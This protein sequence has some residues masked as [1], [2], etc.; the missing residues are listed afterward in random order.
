MFRSTNPKEHYKMYKKGKIWI[1]AGIVTTSLVLGAAGGQTAHADTVGDSSAVSQKM[2]PDK[3]ATPDGQATLTA[4]QADVSDGN[5][6]QVTVDS[7]AANK[8][9]ENKSDAPAPV[10][11]PLADT[12]QESTGD[13]TDKGA[14]VTDDDAP[15]KTDTPVKTDSLNQNMAPTPTARMAAPV[16]AADTAID[17]WMPNKTLQADVLSTLKYADTSKNPA[18]QASGKTW[19]TV[20]DITQADMLLLNNFD[21]RNTY[22]DGKQSFSIKGLEFATNLTNLTISDDLNHSPYMVRGDVTDLTPLKYLTKL[23][24]LEVLGQRV[25]DITP[26][27]GLKNVKNL[28][29]GNNCIADFSSLNAAQYSD[30][31]LDS[32]L[33][34]NELIYMPKTDKYVLISPV[35]APQGLTFKLMDLQTVTGVPITAPFHPD[36]TVRAFW[37]GA[38]SSDTLDGDKISY[39]GIKDQIMPGQTNNPWAQYYPNLVQEDYA[40]FLNAVYTTTINGKDVNVLQMITPYVK[41]DQAANVTINYVDERGSKVAEPDTLT[42]FIGEDYVA[43]AKTIDGY[44]LKKTPDNATGTFSNTA[45][46]VTFVYKKVGGTVTPPVDPSPTVVITVHYETSNGSQVASDVTLTGKAG[47]RYT[48]SPVTVDGYKLITSPA[49]ATGTFGNTDSEITYVYDAVTSGGNADKPNQPSTPNKPKQPNKP[50]KITPNKGG[51]AANINSTPAKGAA[52]ATVTPLS[53]STMLPNKSKRT[54][55]SQT[56]DETTLPQ[57]NEDTTSPLWGLAVLGSLLGLVGVKW[58]K[59]TN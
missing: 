19:T 16:V 39:A 55:L 29:I 17:T 44:E 31:R 42:G 45:Q 47:E 23:T 21:F 35:K 57:T 22:I 13:T 46:T 50:G 1:V 24:D 43:V 11:K 49:N 34:E 32:Q 6:K 27:T 59:H 18:I 33:I 54:A 38:I 15:V 52:A 53:Q 8:Q 9:D 36:S 2:T 37:S 3:P 28:S 48:S 58:R 20:D 4:P 40:Y 51:Q 41:A 10:E 14:K 26:I 5:Q 7:E 25:W 56:H 30:L 12:D